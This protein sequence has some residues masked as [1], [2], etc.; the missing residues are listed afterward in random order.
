[1]GLIRGR[2]ASKTD[3]FTPVSQGGTKIGFPVFFDCR[4]YTLRMSG[5]LFGL[6]T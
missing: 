3:V 5:I 4:K 6:F 2:K 1:M